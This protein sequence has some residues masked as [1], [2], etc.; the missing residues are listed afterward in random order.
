MDKKNTVIGVLLLV[1]AF[2]LVYLGPK[3]ER[4]AA[5]MPPPTAGAPALSTAAGTTGA[6]AG[7][8]PATAPAPLANS[9]FAAAVKDAAGATVTTLANDF[10]EVH[11]TDF[12]GA[13]REVALKKYPT[14]LG[15]A[16]AYAF[17]A[18]H[19][20]PMLAFVDYPGLDRTVR[21]ERVSQTAND[22]VYRAVLDGR[23]EVTRRYILPAG[24]KPNPG[25]TTDPYQVRH[26]TTF[27]NLT[28][29]TAAL[30]RVALS[31]GTAAPTGPRDLGNQLTSGSSDGK[32][33]TF[34]A[35]AQL[36]ASSGFLGM[37]ASEL[38]SAI[39]RSGPI[40][41][42]AVGNQ[43]FTT[44]LTPDEP[45]S[46]LITRRVK[47]FSALPDEDRNAYGLTAATQFDLKPLAAHGETKLALSF[48]VGPK[49]Y[50]RLANTNVFKAD[51]DK[52]MQYGFWKFFSQLLITLMTWMHGF[53]PN[54]GVAIV[55]MTLTLKVVFLPLTLK[56]S[57][58]MKRMA[59]LQPLMTALREKFKDN[60]AKQQAAMMELYKEHKVNPLGGCLPMLI[61]FPFFIG[62]FSM[63]QSTAE[64]RFAPFLWAPDLAAPDTVG[65]VL[66]LPL[67]IFPIL[68][69]AI[70][71]V[72]MRLTPT[73][74]VDNAQAKMMQFM[75]LVF[76]FIYY[77]FPSA[78]SVYSIA[79]GTF[80]I[81]QQ[82]II[83]RMKEDGDPS[84][85]SIAV[86]ASG[87]P[88][89]NVTPKKK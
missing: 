51:Q 88:I 34:T 84:H 64:L 85:A 8:A 66:G 45:G 81:I 21:Y 71:F 40:A 59:K 33:Q 67:N 31:L 4:P 10:V 18:Q 56:A 83:N 30:P 17:N 47:L 1:A 75:P 63:L 68:L 77:T 6:P 54:W 7:T 43:F 48:Y 3:P 53:A 20:D 80:T 36:E 27:R 49:E 73:P 14:E 46:G 11:F 70:T 5:I 69:T 12:G 32:D 16:T 28:T 25:D 42:G 82:V 87:K 19:A 35:R 61:P 79:N 76:L 65:H 44:V 15:S 24:G 50:R 26:E 86:P 9:A 57:R 23:L 29:E 78:I 52:V 41:W 62:F 72:Q 39:A 37:G 22:V 74:T 55:L 60:P 13:I 89:K 2:A 38:K 58:S